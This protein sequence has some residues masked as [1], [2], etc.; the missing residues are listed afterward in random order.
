MT[1][2][3]RPTWIRKLTAV[4]GSVLVLAAMVYVMM[5]GFAIVAGNFVPGLW[6]YLGAIGLFTLITPIP[7][8]LINIRAFGR[9][10]GRIIM[11][12]AATALFASIAATNHWP[13]WVAAAWL[14]A[15]LLAYLTVR[16]ILSIPARLTRRRAARLLRRHRAAGNEDG[17][18]L[19]DWE[20]AYTQI[21][22][23]LALDEAAWCR[24]LRTR[25]THE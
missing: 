13:G 4:A 14:G 8:L 15:L 11:V 12:G 7:F 2:P 9:T 22:T 5:T 10:A 6:G 23:K 18:T 17:W 16:T 24:M 21:G 19:R 3:A 1:A 25:I 20:W